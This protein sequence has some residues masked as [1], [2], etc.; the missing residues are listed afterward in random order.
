MDKSQIIH[1]IMSQK[2]IEKILIN[3][4]GN[5]GLT[6]DAWEGFAN[7]PPI[8]NDYL[9]NLS[10]LGNNSSNN[11]ASNST[12]TES[13][14][15]PTR[16]MSTPTTTPFATPSQT[17][18]PNYTFEEKFYK[19]DKILT[20]DYFKGWNDSYFFQSSAFRNNA[21]FWTNPFKNN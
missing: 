4:G 5:R 21:N 15:M 7:L 14:T 2:D 17:N 9:D 8:P 3:R 16:S 20:G 1:S 10:Y 6:F 11:N 13:T 18:E 12:G 19:N